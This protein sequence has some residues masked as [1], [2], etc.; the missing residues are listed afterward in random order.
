MK[1]RILEVASEIKTLD[2][3]MVVEWSGWL[4]RPAA[5]IILEPVFRIRIGTPRAILVSLSIISR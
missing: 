3:C 4:G 5:F 2:K 1:G